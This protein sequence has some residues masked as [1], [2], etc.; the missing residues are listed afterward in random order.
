MEFKEE[1]EK[2]V[3]ITIKSAEQ[4]WNNNSQQQQIQGYLFFAR[5]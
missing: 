2:H 1:E 3:G 5:N 4:T